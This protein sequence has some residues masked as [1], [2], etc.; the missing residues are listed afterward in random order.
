[1]QWTHVNVMLIIMTFSLYMTT[2]LGNSLSPVK[3]L[4][5]PLPF[6]WRDN[7]TGIP[8]ILG[9]DYSEH[10][11]YSPIIETIRHWPSHSSDTQVQWSQN[12]TGMVNA[13]VIA[14]LL[15]WAVIWS[16]KTSMHQTMAT[17]RHLA[18]LVTVIGMERQH[19][20]SRVLQQ[21]NYK[22]VNNKMKQNG[23]KYFAFSIWASRKLRRTTYT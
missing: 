7:P 15:R 18:S 4:C 9:M 19:T 21:I 8:N 6:L 5:E 16:T 3:V 2:F 22:V 10:V 17:H 1:M 14:Q 12:D 23:M 20:F 13:K 11:Y